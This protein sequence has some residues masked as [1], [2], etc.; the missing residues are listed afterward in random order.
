MN[1]TTTFI[2]VILVI[3]AV[4]ALVAY[5]KGT[6]PFTTSSP[7]PTETPTASPNPNIIE[8]VTASPAAATVTINNLVFLPS[9]I[10]VKKGDTVTWTNQDDISHTVTGDDTQGP[11]SELLA[12]GGTYSFTFNTVGTFPYH[13]QVHPTMQGTVIVTE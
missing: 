3:V 9:T 1:R 7:T 4:A 13:C 8:S 5:S 12:T 2:V 10:T 11:A 6:Y